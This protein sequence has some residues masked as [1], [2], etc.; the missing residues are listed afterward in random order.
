MKE[1]LCKVFCDNLS[2]RAVPLGYAVSTGFFAS[3][4]DRIGFYIRS[5]P[6]SKYRIQDNGG[7]IPYLEAIGVNF[8]SGSRGAA[9]NDL[10]EEY[11]VIEDEEARQFAMPDLI[12][13]EIPQAA[14]KFVAFLLRVR[15]FRLMTEKRV[16]STFREDV[17]RA[18][19]AAIGPEV[20]LTEDQPVSDEVPDFPADFVLSAP[21]RPPVGIYLG[22]SDARVLE[23][24][25]VHMRL[26]YEAKVPG[27]IMA[28]IEKPKSV[29]APVR[30]QAA[31]R[32]MFVPEFRGD[33]QQA[34]RM[35]VEQASGSTIH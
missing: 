18:L 9:M 10:L 34:I 27:R 14:V 29:S 28:L 8:R 35:I 6:Q 24:I 31:N 11:S 21:D 1:Q 19:S 20:R 5:E 13:A 33:E 26:Q 16:A 22:T 15:D 12:E 32:L 25:F 2:V 4:G 30:Q 7:V 17:R 23:A 3:D